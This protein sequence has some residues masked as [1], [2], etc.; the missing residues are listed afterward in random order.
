MRSLENI[1]EAVKKVPEGLRARYPDVEWRAIAA[2]RD[3]LI[4]DYFGV[5]FELVWTSSSIA[6]STSQMAR[7]LED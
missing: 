7:I 1:G 4:Y 3:R 2:M 6:Y 5:D